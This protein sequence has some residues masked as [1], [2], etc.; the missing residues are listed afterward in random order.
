MTWR[1][2][3]GQ[4][5]WGQFPIW[6]DGGTPLQNSLDMMR[7]RSAVQCIA[8]PTAPSSCCRVLFWNDTTDKAEL[9]QEWARDGFR[10]GGSGCGVV[11]GALAPPIAGERMRSRGRRKRPIPASA[12]TP[13]PTLPSLP[14]LA[15]ALTDK[16]CVF[17][18]PERCAIIT[19][20]Q[21]SSQRTTGEVC[22][23][24]R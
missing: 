11:A 20:W 16:G 15:T 17:S 22:S 6:S 23:G 8:Q 1:V 4:G 13:A 18:L 10:R 7:V 2:R 24:A 14:V 3:C 21:S 19:Q 9:W 12:T 5:T